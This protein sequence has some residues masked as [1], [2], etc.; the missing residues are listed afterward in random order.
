VSSWGKERSSKA[1]SRGQIAERFILGPI[2]L[3][4]LNMMNEKGL[5]K[6]K[7]LWLAPIVLLLIALLPLP[8][9]YYQIMRWIVCGCA[10]YIAYQCYQEQEGWDKVVIIFAAVAVLYNPI[11]AIHLFREAWMVINILTVAVFGYGWR[12]VRKGK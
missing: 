5:L 1:L 9:A 4:G 2:A 7:L 11:G 6:N 10:S 3:L 12:S 8:Y